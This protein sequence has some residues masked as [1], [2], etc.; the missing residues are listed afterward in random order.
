MNPDSLCMGCMADKGF[1]DACSQCG[2][3]EGTSA[4][5]PLQ[6][7][8][9]TVLEG[10]Y[11]L[12]R[13]LG[14]GGFGITYL[15]WDLSLNRK[16]AI[17]EYFP[18]AVSTRAEDHR[19]VSPLSNK[20]WPDFEYGLNKFAEEGR[21]LA[22]FKGSTGIVSM[23]SFFHANGTAYIV[24]EYV[25][26]VTFKQYLEQRGG[27]IQFKA[28]LSVFVLVTDALGE[29]HAAGMLHR[30]I[31]PDNIYVENNGQIKI[32]DF[33]ATRYAMGE[34]SQSLSVV[35]K[36]GYAPEEQYRRRGHQ[37]PWTDVYALAATFYRAI[38][39][40]VPPEAPDRLAHDEL[41]PPS[42]LGVVLPAKS[43]AA[44]LKALA[45][46]AEN[47]FQSVATFRSAVEAKPVDGLAALKVPVPVQPEALS[48]VFFVTSVAAGLGLEIILSAARS[49]IR[50][51]PRLSAVVVMMVLIYRLWQAIQDGHA[52]TSPGKAI[53]FLFI[54]AFNFYWLFQ[55]FWG[56][57]RDY[58]R[59]VS[60][61]SLPASK[62]PE[63]LFLACNITLTILLAFFTIPLAFSYW[64][65]GVFWPVSLVNAVVLCLAVAKACDAVNRLGPPEAGRKVSS[66]K[67]PVLHCVSGEF[68]GNDV[69]LG[70]QGIIIGRSAAHS[71][72]VLSSDEVSARH[73]RVWPDSANSGIWVEDM[74]STNGTFY[75]VST[76]GDAQ[77]WVRLSGRKLLPAGSR[78]RVGRNLAE[79]EVRTA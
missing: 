79:F 77:E 50:L 60:R 35:L 39:G 41:I 58:N 62:L 59:F 71:N 37:G 3:R 48:K 20:S 42:R 19:S 9:R 5:T 18:L 29:V 49:E 27:K 46:R 1:A 54:P 63:G 40:Q 70:S 65:P 36:P 7:A 6:L 33:G 45:V 67:P 43:E 51:V 57:S 66:A 8:P 24:M 4:Y 78:F 22:R 69:Q 75:R 28:A 76:G 55:V 23:F 31:S 14:Q 34:Q 13:A 10:R 61:H 52:R 68:R 25:E 16:L 15:A 38:T 30:D 2:W 73:V 53:G 47:R 56:F 21:N 11:L 44:L 64:F 12:G 74:N 72:L 26:G 17:K 32:L